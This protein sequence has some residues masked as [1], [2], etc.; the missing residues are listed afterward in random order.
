MPAKE[1]KE[2]NISISFIGLGLGNT[3]KD[4][5]KYIAKETK[6]RFYLTQ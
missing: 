1:A 3:Y 5:L 6:G 4:T 2:K